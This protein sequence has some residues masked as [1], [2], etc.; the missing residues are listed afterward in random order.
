VGAKT[1][2]WYIA[3][4]DLPGLH[5]EGESLDELYDR[6]FG[7]IKGLTSEPKAEFALA[8]LEGRWR[9]GLVFPEYSDLRFLVAVQRRPSPT[10]PL[11]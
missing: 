10:T 1:P 2:V 11:G 4:S 3:N 6:L 5:L 9:F 7:G 8:A